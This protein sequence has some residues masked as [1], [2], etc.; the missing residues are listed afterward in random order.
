MERNMPRADHH[1]HCD[2]LGDVSAL[3]RPCGNIRIQEADVCALCRVSKEIFPYEKPQS[4]SSRH[5]AYAPQWDWTLAKTH[6]RRQ[7]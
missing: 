1:H 6:G 7:M 4:L 2:L 5:N 3:A